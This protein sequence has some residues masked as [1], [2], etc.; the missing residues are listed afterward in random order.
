MQFFCARLIPF[1]LPHYLCH[2]PQHSCPTLP[3]FLSTQLSSTPL[4]NALLTFAA[5][6]PCPRGTAYVLACLSVVAAVRRIASL[7]VDR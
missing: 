2:Y 3:P 7:V 4:P 5:P 1:L 6:H